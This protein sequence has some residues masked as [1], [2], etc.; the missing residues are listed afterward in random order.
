[1]SS[2]SDNEKSDS[3]GA[4]I[5]NKKDT[6]LVSPDEE[7]F[8]KTLEMGDDECMQPPSVEEVNEVDKLKENIELLVK[9]AMDVTDAGNAKE[10]E[11]VCME[12]GEKQ[13]E[14]DESLDLLTKLENY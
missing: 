12:A 13:S 3:M 2:E 1:M 10:A 11:S 4:C 5:C 14:L 8:Q 9:K 7:H 6:K